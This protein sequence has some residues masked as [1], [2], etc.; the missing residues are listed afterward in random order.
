MSS[1]LVKNVIKSFNQQHRWWKKMEIMLR[2][3]IFLLIHTI[4]TIIFSTTINLLSDCINLFKFD[5][6]S[7]KHSWKH[8]LCSMSYGNTTNGETVGKWLK[9]LWDGILLEENSFQNLWEATITKW[10]EVVQFQFICDGIDFVYWNSIFLW[11]FLFFLQRN[12]LIFLSNIFF[13]KNIKEKLK[14]FDF[15]QKNVECF[16]T[17]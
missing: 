8:K 6:M 15:L 5:E 14:I 16:R 17:L 3:N 2:L 9:K 12:L 1:K 13:E 10:W 7:F 11:F 4:L